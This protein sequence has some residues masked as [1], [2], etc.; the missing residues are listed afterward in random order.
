MRTVDPY[1]DLDWIDA[2]APRTVHAFVA[3][4]TLTAL[5]TGVEWLVA[6]PAVQIAIG[7]TLG[8]RFCLPCLLYFE[9]IQP[10]V[11]EGEIEDARAPRFANVVGVVFLTSATLAFALGISTVGWALTAVVAALSTL[12]AVTGFCVGCAV[13][14]RIWGCETCPLP[15]PG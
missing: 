12:S 8:R 15:R 3:L 6:I 2:N 4:F 7:L 13:Y 11:G 9:V 5:A 10:R 14:A 1:R